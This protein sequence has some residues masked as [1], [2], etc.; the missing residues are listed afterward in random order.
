MSADPRA[1]AALLACAEPQI[2]FMAR[3]LARKPV[4]R[5]TDREDIEQILRLR[6]VQ[7]ADLYDSARGAMS[8]FVKAVVQTAAAM[9]LREQRRLKRGAGL[10]TISLEAT[11]VNQHGETS[12]LANIASPDDQRRRTGNSEVDDIDRRESADAANG[13]IDSLEPELAKIALALK[14]TGT[15]TGAAARLGISR[16][17]IYAAL[18][19]LRKRFGDVR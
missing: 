12:T 9:L 16:Q 4:L 14:E 19:E 7:K 17:R 8:T 5:G 6:L 15:V 3:Q 11:V 2:R 1:A 13:A 18:P 10:T